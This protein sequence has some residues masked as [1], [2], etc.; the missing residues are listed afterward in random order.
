VHRR[1]ER[2]AAYLAV[3]GTSV[4]LIIKE[5]FGGFLRDLTVN[6]AIAA[7]GISF[8][9][10]AWHLEGR[11]QAFD[12]SFAH[13]SERVVRLVDDL[14]RMIEA[15]ASNFEVLP[16][17]DAF[18]SATTRGLHVEHMR[19][20]AISSVQIV[21]FVNHNKL[22]MDR[23]SLLVQNVGQHP[24]ARRREFLEHQT[25]V[26]IHEWRSLVDAGRIGRL[27]VLRYDFHPTEYEC[28]FD[29]DYLILGLYDSKI[30]YHTTIGVRDALTIHAG[31]LRGARVIAEYVD[32][33]D[34][35]FL[36]CHDHYGPNDPETVFQR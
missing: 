17:S 1:L 25:L 11:L 22:K 16:L 8:V 5:F 14:P 7:M 33:Y 15:A 32:R 34:T 6:A 4:I 30:A 21:Q 27:E 19:V 24:D 28:I 36:H 9:L 31:S 12:R 13:L 29:D 10:V 2:I 23:C 20:Y 18:K 3:V 35:L 26:A